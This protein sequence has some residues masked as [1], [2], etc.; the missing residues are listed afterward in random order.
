MRKNLLKIIQW[1][2]RVL[3]RSKIRRSKPKIVAISGSYGKTSTKEAI[4]YVL[5]KKFGSD[6]GKNWGNMNSVLGLPLAILGLRSYSFGAG[7]LWDILRAKWGYFFY[8]LPKILV[9][10]LGIDKPG[11]MAEL[12]SVVKPDIAVIT[13]ISETHLLELKSLSGVKKEKKMLIESLKKGGVAVLNADDENSADIPLPTGAKKVTFGKKG[14]VSY[15]DLEISISGS[16]FQ[17]EIS[18][19]FLAVKSKLIG[20]HSIKIFLAAASVAR[21][22]SIDPDEIV[23]ALE[24][25]RPQPGRM[26]PVKAKNEILV[27]DDSYN[28]NP[29]SA[30]E[31]LETLSA[32]KW[33][34]RK[35]AILGNMNELGSYTQEGHLQVGEVAGKVV[36]FLVAVGDNAEY[37]AR[38]AGKL[39]LSKDKVITFKT[40]DEVIAQLD[41]LLSAGDLVLVK[42]SQ[43]KMRFE[44]IVKYLLDNSALAEKLLVRQDKKWEK[45]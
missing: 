36:D 7:L 1:G 33:N 32:I 30:I 25:I 44:N 22:F 12:L 15:R 31:A 14:E 37:L 19:K 20:Q 40:T 29:Y 43:N 13:G 5:S 9:L 2:L 23:Q 3:A 38:G 34:G 45:K 4:F 35:V 27:I 42:A 24:E 26:N 16:R 21:E 18:G 17:L 8:N 28:S 11:E 6:V 41:K 10:E 39:G